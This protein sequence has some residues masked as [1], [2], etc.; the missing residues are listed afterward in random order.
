[1]LFNSSSLS[2]LDD[3]IIPENA[4]EIFFFTGVVTALLTNGSALKY[5]WSG[6]NTWIDSGF[7]FPVWEFYILIKMQIN[8]DLAWLRNIK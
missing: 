3:K 8:I 7:L 6:S 1:M 5:D 4:I 2:T